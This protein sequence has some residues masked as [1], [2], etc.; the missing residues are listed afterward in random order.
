MGEDTYDGALGHAGIW[1]VGLSA[2]EV[3]SLSVGINPRRIRSDDLLYYA[4]LN[5]QSPEP[6]V[7]GGASGTITGTP[8]V[9]E[10]PPIPNSI[11]AP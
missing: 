11:V 8:A 3:G 5:G 9:V 6:D 10:E 2:S 7:V 1:D 4:P